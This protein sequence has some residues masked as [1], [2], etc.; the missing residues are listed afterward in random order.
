MEREGRGIV[1]EAIVAYLHDITFY[2]V[3][4]AGQ[5]AKFHA[6]KLNI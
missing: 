5:C 6:V 2:K 3:Q 1:D 4:S